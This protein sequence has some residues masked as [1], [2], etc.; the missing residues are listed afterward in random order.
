MDDKTSGEEYIRGERIR[1]SVG[2]E[3]R[4]NYKSE[5]W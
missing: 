1:T 3:V 5:N 4:I 2:K